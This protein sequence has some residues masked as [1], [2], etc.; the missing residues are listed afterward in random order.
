MAGIEPSQ[1]E[2]APAPAATPEKSITNRAIFK[3]IEAAAVLFWIYVICKLFI[4]DVDRYLIIRVDPRLIWIADYRFFIL[5]GAAA[6]LLLVSKKYFLITA[7]YI[8]FY[9]LILICW[10][11][12]YAIFKKGNWILAF[13]LMN[14][15]ITT[16]KSL[17]VKFV[18]TAVFLIAMLFIIEFSNPALLA[19][20]VFG[21]LVVLIISY[22]RMAMFVFQPSSIFQLYSTIIRNSPEY[23]R[24]GLTDQEIR[25]LPMNTLTDKQIELRRNSIQLLVLSNRF[26]I[27][28]S[29]RLREYQQSKLN[30]LSYAANLFLLLAFTVV[31]YG[32][33]NYA[34]FKFDLSQFSVSAVPGYFLFL[35]YSFHVFL[36][37]GIGE[38]TPVSLYSQVVSMSEQVLAIVLLFIL[39]GLFIAVQSEKYK[40]DLERTI[41][42]TE[43]TGSILEALIRD[44]YHLT[45]E[46]ALEEIRKMQSN[47]MTVILWLSKDIE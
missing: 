45:I 9:P 41:E 12:P 5:I 22:V 10:R 35:Y 25:A 1:G 36:F 3:F 27:F 37:G 15:I 34:L 40:E 16:F 23:V 19:I 13:A 31:S 33:I 39:I 11:I 20:S 32:A 6:I 43:A 7:L 38:I 24:K 29:H 47:M 18:M 46:E 14:A 17:R 30:A 42:D 21:L 2:I 28:F 44:T 8:V 4:F 26:W